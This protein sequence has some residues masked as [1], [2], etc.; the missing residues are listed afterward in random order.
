MKEYQIAIGVE[1]GSA[2]LE[3]GFSSDASVDRIVP[4]MTLSLN[5]SSEAY[6]YVHIYIYINRVSIPGY[7]V[8]FLGLKTNKHFFLFFWVIIPGEIVTSLVF[9]LSAFSTRDRS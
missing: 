5:V 4:D 6:I 7:I 1:E 8:T 9:T 2:R 3:S